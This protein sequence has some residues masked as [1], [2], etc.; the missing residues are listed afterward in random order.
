MNDTFKNIIESTICWN[1]CCWE[2][3]SS[4]SDGDQLVGVSWPEK[5]IKSVKKCA[6][7]CETNVRC[8]GFHYYGFSDDHFGD[9]YLKTNVKSVSKDLGDGRER[10]GGICR[11]GISI[12][13]SIGFE[14]IQN[15][16]FRK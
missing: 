10:Y 15:F 13:R 2:P 8:D 3:S 9:C 4:T 11:K 6:E 5:S 14:K 12:S 16:R 7:L 1:N